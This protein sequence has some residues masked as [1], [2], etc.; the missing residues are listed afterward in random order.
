MPSKVKIYTR[1]GDRGETSLY[2]GKRVLKDTVRVS[3]YGTVDEL[4][5][6]LGMV[7]SFSTDKTIETFLVSVQNDLFVIGASLAGAKQ[8][9]SYLTK[10]VLTFEQFIDSL[11]AD[12]SE[13][14]Q[15]ILPGGAKDAALAHVARSVAR[16]AER[17]LISLSQKEDI[18]TAILVYFNRLS[19]VLFTIGR[20]LNWKQG[21]HDTVWKK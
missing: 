16:R 14:K 4:N 20:F 9:L 18:D 7:V 8:D 10:R 6:V 15:F 5:S 2:G 21:V 13:L 3:A 11:D 1:T 12:L 17:S 19:D